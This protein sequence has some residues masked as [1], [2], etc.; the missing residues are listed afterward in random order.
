MSDFGLFVNPKDGGKVIE[1][2]KDSF[3]LSFIKKITV[4][5]RNPSR[6]ERRK[7]FRVPGLSQYDVVIVPMALANFWAYGSIDIL[8][9]ESYWVSGDDFICEY[10]PFYDDS[11]YIPG[12]DG[13]S[14][15]ILYGTL[16]NNPSDTYGLFLN[17]SANSAVDNFRGVTQDNTIS[18]CVFREKINI[19]DRGAWSLP[20]NIPNKGDACVFLRPENGQTLRYERSSQRVLSSGAGDV[21]VVIFSHGLNLQPSDGLTIWNREGKVTYS[22]DYAPFFKNGHTLTLDKSNRAR[23]TFAKPMFTM[24]DPGNWLENERNSVNIYLA[25][26]GVSG[27][28]ILGRRMWTRSSYPGQAGY[29]ILKRVFASTYV[30]DFNDYF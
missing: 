23:S 21:Y 25:G 19:G 17:S 13:D 30:I 10:R 15:F 6:Y 28:E 12:S 5:A 11:G 2:T 9:V 24:D 29:D 20:S 1:L 3:P 7:V 14:H 27:S 26:L 22:S 16:K 8:L 4:N 18:H